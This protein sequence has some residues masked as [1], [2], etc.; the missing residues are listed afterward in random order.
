MD[1]VTSND[2]EKVLILDLWKMM[3]CVTSNVFEKM[4]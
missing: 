4:I 2:F 3:V 1:S